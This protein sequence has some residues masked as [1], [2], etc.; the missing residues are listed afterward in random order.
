MQKN[1]E[2]LWLRP[3]EWI[4]V[5]II[6]MVV[7]CGLLLAFCSRVPEPPTKRAPIVREW[8]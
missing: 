3:N 6:S 1:D 5:A 8:K 7:C 4:A 2:F